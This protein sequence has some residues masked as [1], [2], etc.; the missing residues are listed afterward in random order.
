[1]GELYIGTSGFQY[2]D[3]VG[4]FYPQAIS[5]QAML[6]T[7]EKEKKL[8]AVEL[9]FTYYT[10]PSTKTLAG[11]VKKTSSSFRFTVRSHKEMTHEIWED[12]ERRRLKDTAPVFRAFR[13]GLDPLVES[14]RLGCVLLQFPSFFWPNTENKA[15]LA[16]AR[17]L[18][19]EIPTVVEFRNRA[20]LREETFSFLKAEELGFCIVDEPKLPRLLPY[21]PRATSDVAYFRFHGRNPNWFGADKHE[22]YNYLYSEEELEAF[23]PDIKAMVRERDTYVFFNNCYGAKAARNALELK[24]LLSDFIA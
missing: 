24:H 4:E 7:Y 10:L 11:M 17:D 23:L 8:N 18:L 9:N 6:P 3:W 5:P 2:G 12:R 1:M 15:Y 14:A 22:R 21:E 19:K 20:W 13:E 16:R